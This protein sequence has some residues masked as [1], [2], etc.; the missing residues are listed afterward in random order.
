MRLITALELNSK[1]V[2]NLTEL[3][4]RLRP[5]AP[6][7]WVH[8]QNMHVTLKYVGDWPESRLD[9]LLR[10][11]SEVRV[12]QPIAVPLAGLGYFPSLDR[13]RV[14]WVGAENTAPLRQLASNVDAAL[15]PLGVVPEVR[16]YQPHLTLGR[17]FDGESLD[18][19]HNAVEE[20][21][22]REFGTLNPD[23]FT[24]FESTVTDA[25]PVYRRV[26]EFPFLQVAEPVEVGARPT[27]VGRV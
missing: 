22:S 13:P 6:V 20:L 18:E 15:A 10:N 4:R 23:R 25:G 14:F 3:V 2:A 9:V 27:L 1:V 11:L 17:V 12:T 5:V 24:L 19:L 26:A 8:P 21:P 7:R 16:P